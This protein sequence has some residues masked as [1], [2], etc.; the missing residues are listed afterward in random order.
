MH[1][2][3]WEMLGLICV[4]GGVVVTVFGVDES[5]VSL[6]WNWKSECACGVVG[7]AWPYLCAW[8][9]CCDSVWC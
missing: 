5:V 1:A 6:W 4:L 8:G 3:L 9:S 2:V 7:N